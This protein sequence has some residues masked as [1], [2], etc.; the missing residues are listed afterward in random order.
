[1]TGGPLVG[2]SGTRALQQ[3]MLNLV[4]GAGAP[5]V[6]VTRDGTVTFDEDALTK[7]FAANPDQVKAAFGATTTFAPAAGVTGAV[8]CS[9]SATGTLAGTYPV[10][11]TSL[12]ARE[13]WSV[14]AGL[15]AG[16]IVNL[17]LG[18]GVAEEERE[19]LTA[20]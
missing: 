14:N 20:E 2:D 18:V 17:Q 5:G 11:V 16:Q 7:A 6:S 8:R 12:S 9:S 1:K 10:T 13:Q 3:R 19:R 4:A 15:A